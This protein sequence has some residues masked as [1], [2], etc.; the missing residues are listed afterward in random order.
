MGPL[1]FLKYLYDLSYNLITNPKLFVDDTSL[2][3]IVHDPNATASNLNN[4]QA[5][6]NHWAY[7]WKMNFKPEKLIEPKSSLLTF[8]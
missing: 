3:F 4:D 5:K 2:F 1:F 8:Q 6:I 7:Q